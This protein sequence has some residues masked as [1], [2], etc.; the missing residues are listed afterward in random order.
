MEW[1]VYIAGG[2]TIWALSYCGLAGD[3]SV[4]VSILVY[5]RVAPGRSSDDC[6]SD[7]WSL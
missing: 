6:A 5:L 1:R 3:V 7:L 2:Q 4:H